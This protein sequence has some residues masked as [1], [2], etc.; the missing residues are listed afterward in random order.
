MCRT[1]TFVICWKMK[2]IVKTR[3]QPLTTMKDSYNRRFEGLI[4][5]IKTAETRNLIAKNFIP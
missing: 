3:S 4:L 1:W 5:S 2:F